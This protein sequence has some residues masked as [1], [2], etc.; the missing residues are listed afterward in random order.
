M[1]LESYRHRVCTCCRHYMKKNHHAKSVN[2]FKTDH[3]YAIARVFLVQK[4][5]INLTG[6]CLKLG[7]VTLIILHTVANV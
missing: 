4:I 5:D 1:I 6:K 7:N 2:N 3:S